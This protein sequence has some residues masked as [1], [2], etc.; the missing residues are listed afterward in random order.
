MLIL[1]SHTYVHTYAC[2]YIGSYFQF[3][4]HMRGELPCTI[5]HVCEYVVAATS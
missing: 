1:Y 5:I 4:I 2:E 3:F